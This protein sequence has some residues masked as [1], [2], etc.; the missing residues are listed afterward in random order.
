MSL[1]KEDQMM[2]E[3]IISEMKL[4]NNSTLVTRRILA[5]SEVPQ[6]FAKVQLWKAATLESEKSAIMD[7]IKILLYSYTD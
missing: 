1:T 4:D 5:L 2:A 6:I 7:E 3:T